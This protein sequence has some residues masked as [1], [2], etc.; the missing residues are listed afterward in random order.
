ME[1]VF[2]CIYRY[3]ERSP[4]SRNAF[5]LTVVAVCAVLASRI[6]FEEDISKMLN[7]ETEDISLLLEKTK[8]AEQMVMWIYRENGNP[9]K[10]ILMS[11]ADT[12]SEIIKYR[13]GGLLGE[14][15]TDISLDENDFSRIYSIIVRNF[16]LFV[17]H[18]RYGREMLIPP[19]RLDS[20]LSGYMRAMSTQG[21]TFV[22]EGLMYDPAGFTFGHLSEMKEMQT[23][24]K[25]TE[26]S[27]YLFSGDEK[28]IIILMTPKNKHGET[29]NNAR[30][31]KLLNETVDEFNSGKAGFG[32]Y[33]GYK[34]QYFG[35]TLVAVGN[36]LQIQKDIYITV[37]AVMVCILLLL[38]SVFGKKR[39]PLLIVAT[40]SFA[41]LFSLAAVSLF[42]SSLSL[43]AIGAAAVILGIAVNYPI[44]FFTHYIHNRD[45]EKTIKSMVF[46]MTVGSLTT[47]GGFLC[48]TFTGSP[49]LQDFGLFGAF[50]LIGA[51]LFSLIFLPHIFGNLPV[52]GKTNKI[53]K[54]FEKISN[55][56]L[57]K[58]PLPLIL[59]AALTPVLFYFSFDVEYESDLNRLNYMSEKTEK[60]RDCFYSAMNP[61]RSILLVSK[62]YTPEEAL[63]NSYRILLLADSLSSAGYNCSYIGVARAVPPEYIQRENADRWNSYWTDSPRMD[64]KEAVKRIF[65]EK[66]LKIDSFDKFFTALEGKADIMPAEDR[67]F[68]LDV[69]GKDYMY[70]DSTVNTLISQ[71]VTDDENIDEI[72]GIVNGS[73]YARV[74]NKRS[75]TENL[76]QMAGDDF[77]TVTLYTS[78][79]VFLAI[80]FSYGRI[81]LAL[82]TFVPMLVS[83][84]WILGIMGLTGIK[85]NIVNIILSTFIFGLGDDFCIFTTDGCLK[86]YRRKEAHTPV[87]RM[88]IIISGLAGLIG[89]G[90]LLFAKHPAIYSLASVSIPGILSVLFISQTVQPFLFRILITNPASKGHPPI[91][92]LTV[93]N[94]LFFSVYFVFGCLLLSVTSLFIRIVPVNKK[95]KRAILLHLIHY[96]SKSIMMLSVAVKKTVINPGCETLEKPAII[97]A[98]HQSMI[99]IL[100]ILALSPKIVFMV[101]G[102]VWKSPFMGL[103]V[104][105]AGFHSLAE[106][107]ASPENYRNT[108]NDGYSIFIF[109]EGSRTED[110][111]I[112]RFH[113]GAFFLAEQLNADILPLMIQNNYETLH[114]NWYAV[115]PNQM[116]L[117]FYARISPENKLF[118]HDYRER[119]KAI[120]AFYRKEYPALGE[121]AATPRYCARKLRD[122]FMYKGPVL[123]WYLR[124]KLKIENA[125]CSFDSLVPSNGKIVDAG[126]G[127][128]FLSYVLAIKSAGRQ[129]TGIDYDEDKITVAANCYIKT[130]RLIF[131]HADITKYDFENADCFIFSDVLHYIN[132]ENIANIAQKLSKKLNSGGKI[133]I[134]DVDMSEHKFNKITEFLSTKIFKFN[135]TDNC[136]N[137]FS[138]KDICGIFSKY[139]FSYDI[140]TCEKHA[141]NTYW[142]LEI[143]RDE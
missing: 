138:T 115:Y 27:G 15:K 32:K 93:I 99:D 21:G 39:L 68:L 70:S 51:V 11:I 55:Y 140:I 77:N 132:P 16:P 106:G 56:P 6:S 74:L 8:S 124:I 75:I 89:F 97:I 23:A 38:I 29:K 3:F 2:A 73:G 87:I 128:G 9:D 50:C 125:Y 17:S 137:F 42:K 122:A 57:D 63:S 83:W 12:L 117:K 1:N 104:R 40:V 121:E 100:Q 88:S 45:A 33:S 10:E 66:G 28:N 61:E 113:K 48:L 92:L 41:V 133:I 52:S 94:T 81:E 58:K 7:T 67:A 60:I 127:Y 109:P 143:R 35:A 30:L 22:R 80:L 20:V 123:E 69:F 110:S 101:K 105:H 53:R 4:K 135:K 43:I 129:I 25:F 126:C 108:L 24:S 49:L 130:D 103:F 36:S 116:T 139:G 5:L 86:S 96:L 120:L 26:I 102:W 142:V 107:V 90:T 78:L 62:G 114:K 44:H 13:C 47:I 31:I 64:E 85:F 37:A 71:I 79:L 95:K 65:T 119:T 98:N 82:I 131:K 134:R 18:E 118:G 34:T 19:G 111:K 59:I 84:I 54:F 112:K 46:P 72:T 136:P 141:T 91:S 14:V 76:V